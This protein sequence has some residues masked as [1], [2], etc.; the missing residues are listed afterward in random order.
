MMMPPPPAGAPGAAREPDTN[1][2]LV[3]IAAVAAVIVIVV[4]VVGVGLVLAAAHRP[5]PTTAAASPRASPTGPARPITTSTPLTATTGTIVFTDDFRD[6]LS[7]WDTVHGAADANYEYAGS[8]F[9][10]VALGSYFY[11]TPSPYS[12]PKRQLSVGATATLDL[13]TPPD[14]GFGVDCVR[15]SGSSAIQYL[16]VADAD[17]TWYVMRYVGVVGPTTPAEILKQG[18]LG[19]APAPGVIPV[20]LVGVCATMGDGLTT[21]LAF[22]VDGS[23]VADFTDAAPA[24]SPDGWLTDLDIAGSDL[25]AVT[26]TVTH[27]EESDL[28]RSGQ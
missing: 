10:A 24:S 2:R 17:A 15:G 27:F 9:V 4:G 8:A 1:A 12:E 20:T 5:S 23:K 16:F 7:G 22:F 14:A 25:R 13:H 26:V 21:R 6:P 18:S 19:S 11:W 3:L 28:S